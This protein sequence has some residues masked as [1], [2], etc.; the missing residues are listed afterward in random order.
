MSAASQLRQAAQADDFENRANETAVLAS[1]QMI[2]KPR[3]SMFAREDWTLFRSLETLGQK[4]GV[5]RDSLARLVAKELVDNAL[6]A[7][8]SCTFGPLKSGGFFI[9]DDGDGIPGGAEQIG[10]LFSINRPLTSSKLLRLPTRG[11]LG[12]GLRVVAGVV[13]ATGGTLTVSTKGRKYSLEP[14]DDGITIARQSRRITAAGTRIEV[15]LPA[16]V[17]ES[18][19]FEWAERA[20]LFAGVGDSFAGKTSPW[21]YTGDAFFELCQAAV[22][23]TVRDLVTVFE[24]CAEPKAG[25]IAAPF[26]GRLAADLSRD[27][28]LRLLLTMRKQSRPVKPER[29][30]SVGRFVDGL[31]SAYGK[32][33]A[34][35]MMPCARDAPAWIGCVVEAWAEVAIDAEIS[36]LVNRTPITSNVHAW[37]EKSEQAIHGCGLHLDLPIGRRPIGFHLNITTPYMP[38]TSDGKSPDLSP[39][40][41]A[42]AEALTQAAVRAKRGA[43]RAS[44]GTSL[45]QAIFDALPA[46]YAHASGDGECRASQRQTFYSARDILKRPN[47]DWNYFCQVVTDYELERG[48]I[49][50]MT[51]DPRGVLI[52]PHT[53]EE[54]SLGTIAVENYERPDF[55]FNKILYI[56]KKGFFP[57]L[58]AARWPERHDCALVSSDGFPSRAVRDAIDLLGDGDEAVLVFCVHD[59]DA[60]GTSIFQA[61]Q[62][63]T[64]ARPRRRVEV[65]NLGLEP[66]EAVEMGLQIESLERDDKRALPVAGY[67]P[68]K[69]RDWLQ[70]SRVEL[71]AMTSPQFIEWLDRKMRPY[72]NG[73]VIPPE[74]L[75]H[76]FVTDA[77]RRELRDRIAARILEEAGI[78]EQVEAA[79][80]RIDIRGGPDLAAAVAT[81]LDETGEARWTDP[82]NQLAERLVDA[83]QGAT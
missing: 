7:G 34:F 66:E 46:A 60:A 9:Q 35:I 29:L 78:N 81:A 24:G 13:L 65:I 55:L 44:T 57:I 61:L 71:N 17:D 47:L 45:K 82:L 23:R 33:T 3:S 53:G 16:L 39:L 19:R 31:P 38:I 54:V 36:V 51:R 56:E 8:A 49:A 11:A 20:A 42:I 70:H 63:A 68:Q 58:K 5:P 32:K 26:K 1:Q 37:H 75:M 41:R 14:R 52:H 43:G 25:K 79:A 69:W 30:G 28:A 67:V 18:R 76:A 74:D 40:E 6:D 10:A 50:G 15:T 73:K 12:N 59:G 27:E 80:N 21:W 72:D 2:Q 64:K 83:A 22:D 48:E 4:A 62:E 77:V